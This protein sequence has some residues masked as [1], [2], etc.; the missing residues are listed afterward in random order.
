MTLRVHLGFNPAPAM[1]ERLR[2]LL[3]DQAI[4][5]SQGVEPD[6][7]A[8]YEILISGRPTRELIAASPN[9]KALI[10]PW[11]G[12]P[13]H[14]RETFAEFPQ[15]TIHN[16]HHN[17]A[18]TAEL[19]TTLLMA[20]AKRVVPIDQALRKGNWRAR[21]QPATSLQ[22]DGSKCVVLGFGEIGK[23][24]A[25]ACK[26]LGMSVTAIRKREREEPRDALSPDLIA[27]VEGSGNSMRE[28][29]HEHMRDAHA[30]IICLPATPET[31]GLIGADEIALLSPEAVMVNVG[32]GSIIEEDALF[33]ALKSQRIGGAGIDTW[34]LYPRTEEERAN[35]MGWTQPFHQLDN[36]VLSPHRGGHTTRT[37]PLRAEHLA[38]MLIAH[39]NGEALGNQI[40]LNAGY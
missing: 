1:L 5:L 17:A 23:R 10:V 3:S 40:D 12:L 30:L 21:Y 18:A 38:R 24:V 29:L 15:V 39:V 22:L 20:A 36:V 33:A 13:R 16:L 31:E 19:A 28:L 14:L 11:A 4:T 8:S 2:E 6:A 32:R 37:E 27:S 34:Y 9:L 7:Q 25:R 26:A 35:F